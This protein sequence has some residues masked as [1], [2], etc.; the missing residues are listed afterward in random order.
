MNK[1]RLL[2][3]VV[4]QKIAGWVANSVDPDETP[5][6]AASHQGLHCLL[7]RVCPNITLNTLYQHGV[8]EY[9]RFLSTSLL[10][11]FA[12]I[13]VIAIALFWFVIV[14]P[15]FRFLPQVHLLKSILDRYRPDTNR[16]RAD[17]GPI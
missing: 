16:P 5:H 12:C 17:N 15:L 10:F 14:C 13:A 3:D 4:A 6:I 8:Y 11:F 1:Y 7:R 9:M 2:P